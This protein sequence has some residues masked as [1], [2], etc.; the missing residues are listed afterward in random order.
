[1]EPIE[2][3][4]PNDARLASWMYER[5]VRHINR[6]ESTLPDDM[7]AGGRFVSSSNGYTFNIDDVSYWNPDMIIFS[8]TGPDGEKVRLLQHTSQLNLLLVAVPR[9]DDLSKPRRKIGFQSPENEKEK[10]FDL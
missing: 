7:Q 3:L 5:V 9:K 1:M 4:A 8:G 2:S 10:P 6:F